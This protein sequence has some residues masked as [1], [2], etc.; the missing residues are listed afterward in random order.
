MSTFPTLK[1]RAVAQYPAAKTIEFQNQMLRFL[2][3]QEQRYRDSAGPLRRWTIRL[4][5]LDET[6]LASMEEF[7]RANQGRFG[8]FDFTDPWDGQT[9]SNCSIQK[10]DLQMVATDEMR[11]KM[12]LTILQNR[13]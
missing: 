8:S 5:A 13:G 9:Y 3:G 4:E 1:T 12:S 2:D 10:D 6:E 7:F 11:A